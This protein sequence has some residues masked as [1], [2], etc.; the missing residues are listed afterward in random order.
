[1]GTESLSLTESHTFGPNWLLLAIEVVLLIPLIFIGITR[2]PI[3]HITLRFF[4]FAVLLVVTL[5]LAVSIVL[6]VNTLITGSTKGSFLLRSAAL[7]W[8]TNILVF[9]LW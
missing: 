7:L 5:G 2:R 1:V 4:G 8:I 6:L 9:A 3:P